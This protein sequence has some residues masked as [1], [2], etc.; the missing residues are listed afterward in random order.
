M[1]ADAKKGHFSL[2]LTKEVS[3]FARNILDTIAYTRELKQLG[4][5]ILF[6]TDGINTGD[7][8][9]ELRLSILGSLAQEE[10]RR[11]SQR[12]KWG[13]QRRM[14]QGVVFGHALLG[15]RLENG[16]LTVDPD[17]AETVRSIFQKYAVEKQSSHRIAAELS[18][19]TGENWTPTKVIRILKNEKYVGDLV[20]KKTF[21]P[22]FLTHEKKTN[23]GQEPIISI[24]DHHEG[25]IPRDLWDQAQS[26]LYKRSRKRGEGTSHSYQFGFSGKIYCG[27]CGSVFTLRAKKR[28]DGSI[29][30]RWCCRHSSCCRM[31]KTVR[32]ILLREAVHTMLSQYCPDYSV[33][34][35]EVIS[36]VNTAQS[37]V[38]EQASEQVTKKKENI[39]RRIQTILD[40][41]AENRISP[42]VFDSLNKKQESQ[43]QLLNYPDD[44]LDTV[45]CRTH[46]LNIRNRSY[47]GR[48]FYQTIVQKITVFSDHI[49]IQPEGA[50][51]PCLF[52][53]I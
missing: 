19:K 4:V 20:Q 24:S 34:T 22:N 23:M 27:E 40:L 25:L 10:S 11:T 15:Y 44:K 49:S 13:Q 53:M 51:T 39:I 29:S 38:E 41:Y 12:V 31:R 45:A 16:I 36:L 18:L 46:L 5:D 42:E 35:E 17:G 32:D 37:M 8:D 30:R 50:E 1:M 14:E 48:L 6:V 3:R 47:E 33:L 28:K 9:S 21:T 43:L 7:P 26:V 52:L 2:L